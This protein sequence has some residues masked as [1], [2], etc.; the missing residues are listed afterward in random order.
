MIRLVWRT[1]LAVRR[2]VRIVF[3][4][5]LAAGVAAAYS[6]A[7]AAAATAGSGA[8]AGFRCE[9][10]P[11]NQP[12]PPPLPSHAADDRT[13][14]GTPAPICPAQQVAKLKEDATAPGAR[15]TPPVP[16]INYGPFDSCPL[17]AGYAFY[18]Y[19]LESKVVGGTGS[20]QMYAWIARNRPILGAGD[21]HTL[22]QL[23]AKSSNGLSGLN[24]LEMG[25][26]VDPQAPGGN[27][28]PS[29]PHIFVIHFINGLYSCYDECS[30]NYHP[31]AGAPY[32]AGEPLLNPDG[33]IDTFGVYNDGAYWWYYFDG[34]WIGYIPNS[35]W[36][37]GFTRYS[38]AQVGGEV[39]S[40]THSHPATQ[41]GTG[42]YGSTSAG[43][44]VQYAA[45][46][47]GVWLVPDYY[48]SDGAYGYNVG[49]LNPS[50]GQFR[51]GGPGFNGTP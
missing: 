3:A 42:S 37:G 16:P 14:L 34:Y 38:V 50:V 25:W 32:A 17:V 29:Y 44:L 41:M 5:V 2:D 10:A 12:T 39:S 7:A 11:T 20:N 40:S 36:P 23:W 8:A 33:R 51:Y 26:T 22:T 30:G 48:Q 45:I 31:V 43:G 35:A 18:C 6:S 27:I 49:N 4:A 46:G 47:Q 13:R 21:S 9:P 24:D 19:A 15:T 28:F 1:P